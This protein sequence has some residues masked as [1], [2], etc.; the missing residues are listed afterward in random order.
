[1]ARADRATRDATA[2]A[3]SARAAR[4][5]IVKEFALR[6]CFATLD[7]SARGTIVVRAFLDRLRADAAMTDAL[8]DATEAFTTTEMLDGVFDALEEA[9]TRDG[10]GGGILGIVQNQRDRGE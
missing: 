5:M 1:M 2:R 4:R 8:Q 7:A 10:G 3:P 9:A 6:E